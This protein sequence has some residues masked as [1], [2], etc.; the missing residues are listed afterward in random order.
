MDRF[1]SAESTCYSEH[2]REVTL[3]PIPKECKWKFDNSSKFTQVA[4]L[5]KFM[6]TSE[7]PWGQK[8]MAHIPKGGLCT[9]RL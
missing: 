9:R 5:L 7:L 2:F 3:M 4:I 1:F 8:C 6:G